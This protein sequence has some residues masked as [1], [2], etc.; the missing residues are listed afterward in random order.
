[1][2]E[3]FDGWHIGECKKGGT[4]LFVQQIKAGWNLVLR[5]FDVEGGSFLEEEK[6]TDAMKDLEI[7]YYVS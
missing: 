4:V 6:V 1:M 3:V 7:D 2:T 5:L